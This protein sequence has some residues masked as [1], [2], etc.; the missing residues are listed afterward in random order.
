MHM[1]AD[2]RIAWVKGESVLRTACLSF[3]GSRCEGPPSEQSRRLTE[4]TPSHLSC[5]VRIFISSPTTSI[6]RLLT[7][8]CCCI[9]H[10]PR[11]SRRL[12]GGLLKPGVTSQAR[13]LLSARELAASATTTT[14]QQLIHRALLDNTTVHSRCSRPHCTRFAVFV[15][16]L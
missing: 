8:L 15:T 3:P 14:S 13:P 10:R 5:V 12:F 16:L 6:F 4:A 7:L 1:H 9:V 11:R 2:E